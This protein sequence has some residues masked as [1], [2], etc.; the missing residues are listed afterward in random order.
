M[1]L[2]ITPKNIKCIENLVQLLR[3]LCKEEVN[4][5]GEN[6]ASIYGMSASLP[7][8]SIVN[9]IVESYLDMTTNV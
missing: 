8:K 3:D 5:D 2:C 1:H 7:D 9:E 4:N 6:I